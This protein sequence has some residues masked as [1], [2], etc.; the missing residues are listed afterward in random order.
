VAPSIEFT[1]P[2]ECFA[3]SGEGCTTTV[4]LEF[5]ATDACSDAV[6]G[7]ELDANFSGA[8]V[9][10][11]PAALGV[12][13]TVESDG[14]GNYTVTATNVPVGEHAIR[15]RAS[16]G[17]GNFDVQIIEFCVTPICIQTLTVTLM[18][19]GNGGGIAAIWASD[20]IASPIVDCFG[21]TVTDYSIYRT[22]DAGANGFTAEFDPPATNGVNDITCAD[23]GDLS[24]RVYAFDANG[25]T[26]DYCEVVV[27]VQDNANHCGGSTGDLSGLIA[28][29]NDEAMGGVTVELTA[30]NGMQQTTTND[31]GIFA[32]ENLTLGG[33]YTVQPSYDA[34]FSQQP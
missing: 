12:G 21:N 24:V 28:T 11:N 15:V 8:F 10:D 4:V 3:G 32:F 27:Q 5:T 33:D 14:E 22:S 26:P 2:A 18:D 19:D 30:T 20:F 23:V 16:D 29:P 1:E 9:A 17:C 31:N 6:V 13:V 7:V 25:S 34:P